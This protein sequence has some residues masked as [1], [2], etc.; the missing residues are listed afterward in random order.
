MSSDVTKEVT[1]HVEAAV[2]AGRL[3]KQLYGKLPVL[4]GFDWDL[5]SERADADGRNDAV[6]DLPW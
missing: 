4:A 1:T 3:E 5:A 2:F 6:K